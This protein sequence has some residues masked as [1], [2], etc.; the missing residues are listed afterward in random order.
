MRK[1]AGIGDR[2]T[3]SVPPWSWVMVVILMVIR[4]RQSDVRVLISNNIERDDADEFIDVVVGMT[5]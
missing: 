4:R 1:D 3:C 2:S 5:M